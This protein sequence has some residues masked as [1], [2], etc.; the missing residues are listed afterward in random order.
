MKNSTLIKKAS[1]VA[2]TPEVMGEMYGEFSHEGKAYM[3]T[4]QERGFRF[5]VFIFDAGTRELVDAF[6]LS[7]SWYSGT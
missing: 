3:L 1:E 2:Q 5:S 6:A 4:I 7:N